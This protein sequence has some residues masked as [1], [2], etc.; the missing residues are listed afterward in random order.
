MGWE[1]SHLHDFQIADGVTFA[2]PDL[3]SDHVIDERKVTLKQILPRDGSTLVWQYDFGDSWNHTVTAEARN[4]PDP[5]I[6]YPQVLDGAHGPVGTRRLRSRGHRRRG[7]RRRGAQ[8][9]MTRNLVVDR[10]ILGRN[11][12]PSSARPLTR[13]GPTLSREMSTPHH[14]PKHDENLELPV[15]TL[16]ERATVHPPY[17][18]QVIDDL[19]PEETNEFLDAVL[20]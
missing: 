15:E 5:E 17:G 8:G 9:A 11:H 10:R 3:D 2:G 19:T 4:E 12:R 6:R 13:T 7:P 20:T 14:A 1:G 16:L 18:E